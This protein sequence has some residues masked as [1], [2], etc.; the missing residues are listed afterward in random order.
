[1]LAILAFRFLKGPFSSQ[2]VGEGEAEGEKER[3][4]PAHMILAFHFA[5]C[6]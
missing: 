2:N 3:I 1:M 5:E 6:Y 4:S